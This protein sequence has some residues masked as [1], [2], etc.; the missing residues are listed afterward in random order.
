MTAVMQ[1]RTKYKDLFEKKHKVKLGF[2]GF[3]TRPSAMR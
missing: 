3:F 2:M 1:L